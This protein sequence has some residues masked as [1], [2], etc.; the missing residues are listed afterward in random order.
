M[1]IGGQTLASMV[2]N[3]STVVDPLYNGSLAANI[4]VIW[5]GT[6]DISGPGTSPTDIYNMLVSYCAARR[7]VGWKCITATMLSRQFFETQKN[8]LNALILA[9]TT[10]FDGV[11][12]F[13][14]TVL[15][16][17]GCSLNTTYFLDGIHPTQFS[18]DTIEVPMYD[19]AINKISP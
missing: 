3:A 14:G 11:V 10:S 13:T 16:C 12:D 15:G 9:D 4:T 7:A 2:A 18:I 17:D 5:G 8:V 19:T 6:N 1:A